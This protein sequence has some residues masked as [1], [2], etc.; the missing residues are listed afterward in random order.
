MTKA[1]LELIAIMLTL[2]NAAVALA[3]YSFGWWWRG[4]HEQGKRYERSSR[5][6]TT[7]EREAFD[8]TF[9]HMD[10][11]FASMRKIFDK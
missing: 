8:E 6:M 1:D 4:R 5:L 11:A 3:C 7:E 10:R 9:E 2:L